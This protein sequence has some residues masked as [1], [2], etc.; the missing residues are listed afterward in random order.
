MAPLRRHARGVRTSAYDICTAG[1]LLPTV[2]QQIYEARVVEFCALSIS[3][4]AAAR[5]ESERMLGNRASDA[6]LLAALA[7]PLSWLFLQIRDNLVSTQLIQTAILSFVC[8]GAT[9]IAV[10]QLSSYLHRR[11]LKGKDFGRRGT[12]SENEE[13]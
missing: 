4:I 2:R 7:A 10:P 9:V 6:L 12:P 1:R 3:V 8:F 11:G 13:M 5:H